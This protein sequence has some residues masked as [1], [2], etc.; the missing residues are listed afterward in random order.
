MVQVCFPYGEYDFSGGVSLPAFASLK[1]GSRAYSFGVVSQRQDILNCTN[2]FLENGGGAVWDPGGGFDFA[3]N[4]CGIPPGLWYHIVSLYAPQIYRRQYF[5]VY[6]TFIPA[7]YQTGAE[8]YKKAYGYLDIVTPDGRGIVNQYY[9]GQSDNSYNPQFFL[10]PVE[11]ALP[12]QYQYPGLPGQNDPE[13][14][15]F[16]AGDPMVVPSANRGVLSDWT[17]KG[18][19]FLSAQQIW[20]DL[21]KIKFNNLYL[22]WAAYSTMPG[23][24]AEAVSATLEIG[25]DLVEYVEPTYV[26]GEFVASND[27]SDIILD[28]GSV[29]STVTA[30]GLSPG[31]PNVQAFATINIA[32]VEI[33]LNISREQLIA[34]YTAGKTIA[35]RF[36]VETISDTFIDNYAEWDGIN[37]YNYFNEYS[38]QLLG[39]T[40]GLL[41]I[42]PEC[43]DASF[44]YFEVPPLRLI[45]RPDNRG[46]SA[47]PRLDYG[48][49]TTTQNSSSRLFGGTHL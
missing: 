4:S 13:D 16:Y 6:Q 39:Y 32:D 40:Q 3:T 29:I 35:I 44:Q 7:G 49:S 11:G 48:S 25:W 24:N 12:N 34:W 47:T 20:G 1:I 41:Q 15:W 9:W 43:V 21:K 23:F 17:P 19:E 18:D 37:S 46:L 5:Q 2:Y 28:S 14:N 27:H 30:Q 33:N 38:A 10:G 36:Y 31:G 42:K 26:S 45:Q 8:R 22:S